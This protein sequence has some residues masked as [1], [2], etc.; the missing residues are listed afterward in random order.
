MRVKGE[1]RINVRGEGEA[2]LEVDSE[3]VRHRGRGPDGDQVGKNSDGALGGVH[4]WLEKR[5][6]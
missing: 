1:G 4:D 3:L 5:M 6:S 2:A